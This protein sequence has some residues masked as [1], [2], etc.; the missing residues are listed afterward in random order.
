MLLHALQPRRHRDLELAQRRL[1]RLAVGGAVAEVRDVRDPG[2]IL[3]R[4][5]QVDVVAGLHGSGI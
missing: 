2:R 3:V 4:P 5:E 1:R